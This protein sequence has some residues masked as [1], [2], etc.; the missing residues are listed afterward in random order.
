MFYRPSLT[1]EPTTDRKMTRKRS[2][3]S[4]ERT[5]R[6][7]GR[8]SREAWSNDGSSLLQ[9]VKQADESGTGKSKYLA[10]VSFPK[11][12]E[13]L[14]SRE[15][16]VRGDLTSD[17]DTLCESG[18]PQAN[19][20]RHIAFIMDGNRR[21]GR[22][23]YGNTVAGH[24]DGS[25][26]LLDV[27]KWCIAE[28]IPYATVYAF[29]T[30]NWKRDPTEVASLMEIFAKYCE[31]L[32]Q[33]SLARNI[34]VHILSTDTS[35]IPP[36]VAAGLK[37]LQDDT[38]CCTGLCLNVCLSY[39]SRSEMVQVCQELVADCIEQ[40]RDPATIEELDVTERL[41]TK[42]SP[43]PDVLIRT[44]G[45]MRISNYLLWQLAYAELFF[46]NKNWPEFEKDDFLEV[47]RSYS[48]GRKRRFGK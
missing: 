43:D 44:S 30:E 14:A 29:S 19:L 7:D 18:I 23:Q 9:L 10:S 4:E 8:R 27:A 22:K 20:P 21:Y 11:T 42:D 45:E 32:R 5:S 46:L 35:P 25:R 13:E 3:G 31:E 15:N 37:R 47:I 28:K 6:T 2:N 33:E 41:L 34:R 16:H 17:R 1:Q 12:Q 24:W 36:H 48:I 38:Q 26:K 40:D 39:G